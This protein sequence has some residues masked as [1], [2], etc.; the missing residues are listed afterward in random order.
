[1]DN[2]GETSSIS[3]VHRSTNLAIKGS[4]DHKY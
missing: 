2:N 3:T 4:T 1:M